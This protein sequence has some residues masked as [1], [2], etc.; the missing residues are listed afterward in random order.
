MHIFQGSD[1]PTAYS[2]NAV[3]FTSWET[4]SG[5]F[6]W[7][8]SPCVGNVLSSCLATCIFPVCDTH[9]MLIN[10]GSKYKSLCAQHNESQG[11]ISFSVLKTSYF[12]LPGD[13]L[14]LSG[15]EMGLVIEF[16]S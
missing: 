13:R 9:P 16:H 15:L 5:D 6:V 2:G 8:Q 3:S 11:A 12:L 7:V 14:S 10:G 4:H 1:I